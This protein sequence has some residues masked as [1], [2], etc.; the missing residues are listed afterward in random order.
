MKK[1]ESYKNSCN[2]IKI[3]TKDLKIHSIILKIKNLNIA[4]FKETKKKQIDSAKSSEVKR[5]NKY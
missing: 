2:E 1:L 5:G 3:W 4:I